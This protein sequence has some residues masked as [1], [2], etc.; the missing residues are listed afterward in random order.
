MRQVVVGDSARLVDHLV[1]SSQI[2]PPVNSTYTGAGRELVP[3]FTMHEAV[4]DAS[5]MGSLETSASRKGGNA[6]RGSPRKAAG[7]RKDASK[8]EPAANR[9]KSAS[10]SHRR[11]S[12]SPPSARISPRK[13]PKP[14]SPQAV[15]APS[16]PFR[17]PGFSQSP[18]PESVP[19]PTF[20]LL[21]R[22][23]ARGIVSSC[24]TSSFGH[25]VSGMLPALQVAA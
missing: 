25:G 5:M 10:P 23:V 20:G 24:K 4:G 17:C 15:P 3:F 7:A 16:A 9:N 8:A 13:S 2:R 1:E 11:G 12:P 22:A 21:Q 19:L 6:S 14:S 18:K